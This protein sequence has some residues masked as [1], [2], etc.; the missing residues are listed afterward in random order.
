MHL[1]IDTDNLKAS[2]TELKAVTKNKYVNL[3][4]KLLAFSV[5]SLND[6]ARHLIVLQGKDTNTNFTLDFLFG[7]KVVK[8]IPKNTRP[9]IKSSRTPNFKPDIILNKVKPVP[10]SISLV[11]EIIKE[12]EEYLKILDNVSSKA[13]EKE[14]D[15]AK[16]EIVSD[17]RAVSKKKVIAKKVTAKKSPK[18]VVR[19]KKGIIHRVED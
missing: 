1:N 9:F 7:P 8:A 16:V 6:F 18:K 2:L 13:I 3:G 19:V 11:K 14:S 4:T 10:I 15:L 12:E 17:A 5:N